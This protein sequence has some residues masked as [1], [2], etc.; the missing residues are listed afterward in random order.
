[1]TNF[2]YF[3]T[4][5]HKWF[6]G[7]K[8][9][10]ILYKN[11]LVTADNSVK[12]AVRSHGCN[13]GFNSE[14][15]WSGLKDYSAYLGLYAN[16]D[17]WLNHLGGFTAVIDYCT[18]LAHNAGDYLKNAWSTGFLVDKQLC[19]TMLCVRLPGEFVARVCRLVSKENATL[20]YDNAEL[21]QN[22]FYYNHKIEVPIKCVQNDL[23]V[24]ISCHIYN[25]MSDYVCLANVVLD[26]M[27]KPQ[28]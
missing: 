28:D 22:F 21:V 20:S 19:A 5:C 14:F 23:Y 3:F 1:M 26:F 10:A 13:S 6:C 8:G 25:S 24:R 15:I 9:T 11:A 17:I 7:P 2:D 4:N 27:N 12:P 18:N 16:L